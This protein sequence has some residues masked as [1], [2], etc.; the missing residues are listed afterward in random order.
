MKKSVHYPQ[1]VFG[2]IR[3]NHRGT[4]LEKNLRLFGGDNE[5]FEGEPHTVQLF[6]GKDLLFEYVTPETV[7]K[8]WA[9][10]LFDHSRDR[11]VNICYVHYLRFDSPIIFYKKRL[12]MYEQVSE[13][14]FDF[15]GFECELLFGKINKITLKKKGRT[16]HLFDSWSFTQASLARSLE[17]YKLP[18]K[19]LEKS[20]ALAAAIG[21]VRFDKLKVTD[22]LRV[23][24]EEYAKIDAVSEFQLGGKIMDYHA[25]YKVRP[26]ISLPQF[27]ARVFRHHFFK[28]EES[29]PFPPAGVLVPAELS[30]HGGKNGIYD[31]NGH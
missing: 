16:V 6:N 20:K 12:A 28:P 11:G 5:T 21:R 7:F 30:Y 17:M 29:I 9:S 10:Y 1:F 3:A 27:A 4:P 8:T 2:G 18:T 14:A 26:S 19:K 25:E 24:F 31:P 22:P 13:I 15:E 23:E